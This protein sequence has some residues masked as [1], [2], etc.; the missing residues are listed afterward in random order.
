MAADIGERPRLAIVAGRRRELFP[1]RSIYNRICDDEWNTPVGPARA[2][3]G[4]MLVRRAAL[5]QYRWALAE[6]LGDQ[7]PVAAA[8]RVGRRLRRAVR[9]R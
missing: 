4:D 6:T 7:G 8:R 9:L 3:G 5:T 1:D 2:V